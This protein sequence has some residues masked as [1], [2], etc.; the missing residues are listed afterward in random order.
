MGLRTRYVMMK[1]YKA[2]IDVLIAQMTKIRDAQDDVIEMAT[3]ALADA[4]EQGKLLYFWGP[5]GHSS[6]FSEDVLYREGELAYINPIL[7]TNI[8]LSH[9]ALKEVNYFERI[10]GLGRAIIKYH[11]VSK[12]DVLVVGSP[13]GVNPVCIE[14]TLYAKQQ[15]AVIIAVTS[16]QFSDN[17]DNANTM[18]P[19]GKTLSKIA[20]ICV[21]S[22]SLADDLALAIEGFDQKVG[23]VGTILQL[24]ALKCLTTYTIEKL[25]QRGARVP[26][27]RNALVKGGPEFNDSYINDLWCRVK[28]L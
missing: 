25:V 2:Y 27:W 6:I 17:H 12:G 24:T 21:N 22:F 26:V 23:P 11:R 14:G 8:S 13:Y 10:G 9:G 5:G 3:D 15:G 28:S 7:D 20:D 4:L 16:P 18:H 1:A 19:S